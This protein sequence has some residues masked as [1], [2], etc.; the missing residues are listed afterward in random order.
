M[1]DCGE[2]RKNSSGPGPA[3]GEQGPGKAKRCRQLRKPAED[4]LHFASP[5]LPWL[6]ASPIPRI[7]GLDEQHSTPPLLLLH[8]LSYAQRFLACIF[9]A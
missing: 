9:D 8:L 6:E 2:S 1:T 3:G 4:R 5:C 7:F